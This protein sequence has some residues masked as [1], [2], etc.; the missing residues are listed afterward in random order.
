MSRDDLRKSVI[1]NDMNKKNS[2]A[3]LA[4]SSSGSEL[5]M[6][7][8]NSSLR[9]RKLGAIDNNGT[10]EKGNAVIGT[11]LGPDMP[12]LHLQQKLDVKGAII[13]ED[14]PKAQYLEALRTV[15]NDDEMDLEQLAKKLDVLFQEKAEDDKKGYSEAETIPQMTKIIEKKIDILVNILKVLY[16]MDNLQQRYNA[17]VNHFGLADELEILNC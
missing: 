5:G 9:I 2:E 14:D 12:P 13:K 7:N 16:T 8:S 10:L 3:S 17:L 4:A 15:E 6:N 1:L 11:N